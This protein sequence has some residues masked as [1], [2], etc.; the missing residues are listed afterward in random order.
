VR[1][2]ARA[3]SSGP[4]Y[5]APPFSVGSP[6][7]AWAVKNKYKG[8]DLT[9][10]RLAKGVCAVCGESGHSGPDCV[11]PRWDRGVRVRA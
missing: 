3:V 5:L 9:T 2:G 11:N 10:G 4:P 1:G 7:L 8:V 6:A